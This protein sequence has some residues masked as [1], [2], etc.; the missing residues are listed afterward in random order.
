[1]EESGWRPNTKNPWTQEQ[2]S[3]SEPSTESDVCS[4]CHG[5]GWELYTASPEAVEDVY[6]KDNNMH[7]EYARRCTRCFGFTKDT[8]DY[9]NVP[10]LYRDCDIGKFDVNAYDKPPKMLADVMKSFF[11]NFKEWAKKGMGLYLWS[12]TP[13]SGKTFLACCLGK[14]VMMKYGTTLKF[15]TT[16]DYID[17]VS[18]GYSLQKQGIMNLPTQPYFDTDLLILDDIGTQL[19]KP[20]QNQELFKL[21]NDRLQNGRPTIYTSNYTIEKLGIDERIKSRIM[22]STVNI[23]MPE[24]SVRTKKAAQSQQTFLSTVLAR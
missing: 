3:T 6:G 21:I 14:S 8:Y 5:T 4:K 20:W 13:G 2:R 1:M 10:D 22:A 15:I 18:E 12:K 23:P 17:K 19:D 16:V 7:I 24:E 9:T 11:D